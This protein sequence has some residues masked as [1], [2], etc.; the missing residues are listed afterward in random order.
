MKRKKNKSKALIEAEQKHEKFLNRL[1]QSRGIDRG[2]AQSDRAFALGAKGRW[3]ES[4]IPD[5]NLAPTSD[6]IPGFCPKKKENTY[7]GSK[8]VGLATMH[9]SNI[10]PVTSKEN[11]QE[12]GSMRR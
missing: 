2:L 1:F 11:A 9:K 4:S 8:I 5:Q 10:V 12:L 3:F 7:T 6:V